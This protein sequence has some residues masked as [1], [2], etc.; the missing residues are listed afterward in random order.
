MNPNKKARLKSLFVVTKTFPM[1]K[2]ASVVI[3]FM[4]TSEGRNV[5]AALG[6]QNQKKCYI[7]GTKKM[8]EWII[9]G[10][11]MYIYIYPCI[12]T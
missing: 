8:H 11:D 4:A 7:D 10:I 1:I 9:Q 2:P 12:Y 5:A 6:H 3:T